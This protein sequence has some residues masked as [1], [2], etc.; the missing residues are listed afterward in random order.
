MSLSL[1]FVFLI[2]INRKMNQNYFQKALLFLMLSPV[3]L[4]AQ[5]PQQIKEINKQTNV[6]Q[7]LKLKNTFE[8]ISKL[9][10]KKAWEQADIKG[11]NKTFIDADGSVNELIK[12]TVNGNPVYYKTDNVAAAI[13]TRANFLH[14]GGGLG[15]D[16]EGQGMTAHVWDGGI[17]RSS[18][19]EYDGV[20]GQNRFSV[21]DGTGISGRNFHAAH[22]MGTIISSGFV[23]NAKGMA[24]QARGIGYDWTNDTS[25]VALAASNGM[26]ISNHSYGFRAS[27][28]P[29]QWFGAYREDARDFDEIMFNAPYY[30]QVISAGN[31]GND[32]ASNANPL[33]GNAQYDKLSGFK[34]SKNSMIV[35][36]G[37]D[38]SIDSEG[39]L[40]SVT[41]NS[42]SSEGPTDDL[43]IKPD[44]MGNGTGVFS[45]YE[46]ADDAYNTISGTSMAAPNVAGSLLL[47]QQYY[48]AVNGKFMKAA[49]LKGLTLHT[50]DDVNP[51]G[52]DALTGWGL[53][54]TKRAAETITNN[55]LETIIT[56]ETLNDGQSFSI[57]VRSDDTNPLLASISWTDRPGSSTNITNNATPRLINDLDIRVTNT[58]DTFEP[59]RLNAV[60][61]T[62]KGD[63][64]VDPYE[65]V[66]VDGATGEYTI[67]VTHKGTLAGGSQNFSLII[68]GVQ[69]DFTFNTEE[70]NQIVCSNTDAVF[71]FSYTQKNASTTN[72]S[73]QNLPNGASS[74]FSSQT[75]SSSGDFTLTISGLENVPAGSY[76]IIV[77]GDN[78]NETESRTL[79]LRVYQTNF[80]NNPIS[81][82]YPSNEE[83]G[84]NIPDITLTWDQNVN[85]ESYEVEL[86]D[87]PSFSNIIAS[88]TTTN[89]EL[90]VSGLVVNSVY[91]WRTKPSNRCASGNFSDI[92][93]F[94]TAG[95]EDCSNTYTA[96]NF[97]SAEIFLSANNTASVPIDIPDDLIISRLIVNASISHT[98]VQD[99]TLFI[100]EPAGL[101]SNNTVLLQNVCDDT[102][103][104]TNV[105]FDDTGGALNCSTEDPAI[106]GTIIP[107]Q[108]LASSSGKSSSG[109]WFFA[110]TDNVFLDGGQIDAASIT[111]CTSLPNTNVPSFTN[112]NI[113]I[114]ANG[115]YTF[116]ALDIE[117]TT[118]SENPIDQVYTLVLLPT[119]GII[120]KNG[121]TLNVGDTF[122]QEDVNN[123]IV[124]YV[125]T[126][127]E[128][129]TDSF[130]V[131][132]TN[133]A[134][135]W[136][137]NQ[138]INLTATTLSNQVLEIN[139]LSLYPNPNFG[140]LN[141]RLNPKTQSP[142]Q[143]LVF[144]LQGRTILQKTFENKTSIFNESL[145]LR[146]IANG[147]YLIKITE[148]NYSSTKRIVISK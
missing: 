44:I 109:R 101:G 65:R 108:S 77:T 89:T 146:S 50:A 16:I 129:F 110:A 95:S 57:T 94:Q 33:G 69:S 125:N 148:G 27:D 15:L 132:I 145:N 137:P 97:T 123:S 87:S 37:L 4:I 3:F 38:A 25:E 115:S 147:I 29:D 119:K 75:L 36:N 48:N 73:V 91:Y 68:S 35:A 127:T 84:V 139:G 76:D 118:N 7:L 24:P 21:G 121:V 58:T 20:G 71:N 60:N 98:S 122:T 120:Q 117:A 66:N 105:T 113:D 143:V 41:R 130:K 10:K 114:A 88:A 55:G 144:D 93:S 136:L 126:Q 61:M 34:T 74:S 82:S 28:I 45:T 42:S 72:F 124:T 111:I 135:G 103:N 30:L 133:A 86:S 79:N 99:L 18:H 26:L 107:L 49:T 8:S 92:F 128:L 112:S 134:N 6:V 63:N 85:S 83:K 46:S 96:T 52:P 80:E 138:T 17:A 56:E 64:V 102:D 14:N 78:G 104:I 13:S 5:T 31:D 22:V 142:I 32:N 9:E 141:L 81:I 62:G 40:I 11:W 106:S 90:A 67:T 54:N 59:W 53:M 43:R 116:R 47:L 51:V 12:L 70:A 140:S 1:I 100:Q 131:D 19:Q 2:K 23:A 39:N